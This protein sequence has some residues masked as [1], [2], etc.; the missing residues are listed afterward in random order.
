[1]PILIQPSDFGTFVSNME[2]S[3]VSSALAF[4]QSSKIYLGD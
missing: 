2:I 3:F 4:G 1:M